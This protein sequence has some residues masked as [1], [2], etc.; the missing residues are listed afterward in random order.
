MHCRGL[1]LQDLT[2]MEENSDKHGE[3]INF[4]KQKLVFNVISEIQRAQKVEYEIPFAREVQK[5][6]RSTGTLLPEQDL[7]HRS[8][9]IEPKNCTRKD[10]I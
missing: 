10:L 7:Y 1:P 5:F 9:M 4:T 3:M 8:L 6:I 2:F